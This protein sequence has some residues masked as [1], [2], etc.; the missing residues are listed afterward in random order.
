[1]GE[2]LPLDDDR[3]DRTPVTIEVTPMP[4]ELIEFEAEQ[5]RL[6]LLMV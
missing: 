5:L 1:V 2:E 6:E 3:Y 4:D